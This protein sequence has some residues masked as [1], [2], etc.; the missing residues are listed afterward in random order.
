VTG[1]RH[2]IQGQP[3]GFASS[4]AFI[5]GVQAVAAH[6]LSFDLCVTA[7]Q[8]DEAIVLV[9]ECPDARFVLDHCGK[10]CIRDQ[11]FAPWARQIERMAAYDGVVCKV[12]GLLTE[13]TAAQRN[14]DA[15]RPYVEHVRRC[16]GPDRVMYGSDWP[17]VDLAGGEPLWRDIMSVL[18]ADWSDVERAAFYRQ[19]AIRTYRMVQ[20]A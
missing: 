20:H 18:T 12:S 8:L 19:T 3:R 9:S 17:V 15:L 7:D 5:S 16:F 10:P 6:Q 14:V 4:A 13:A 11:S 2:N 1:I